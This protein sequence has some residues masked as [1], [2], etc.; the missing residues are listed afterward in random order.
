M[1]A[2]SRGIPK[3]VLLGLLRGYKWAI[4]PMLLPSCRYVPTCSEY[5]AEAIDRYG[6]L[7]GSGMALWRLLRCHPFVKG[8]CDPVPDRV[9]PDAL[10][11]GRRVLAHVH[12]TTH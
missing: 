10:V 5:A 4:S 9:A 12:K 7:R 1:Y 8:G 6:A 3:S 11:R 2:I